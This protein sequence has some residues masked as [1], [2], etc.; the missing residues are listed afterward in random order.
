VKQNFRLTELSYENYNEC[1][2]RLLSST[3]REFIPE[4]PLIL[5]YA[6]YKEPLFSQTITVV[7]RMTMNLVHWL[8]MR[9]LLMVIATSHLKLC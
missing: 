1:A 2:K 3:D 5:R 8:F 4:S 9:P 6:P 7:S